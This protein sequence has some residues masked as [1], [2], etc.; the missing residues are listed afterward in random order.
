MD[1]GVVAISYVLSLRVSVSEKSVAGFRRRSVGSGG[2]GGGFGSDWTKPKHY[3]VDGGH[4]GCTGYI[5]GDATA[6]SSIHYSLSK[7]T[8]M[9]K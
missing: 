7:L 1:A 9:A 8:V 4:V 6:S 2:S 5:P 3:F